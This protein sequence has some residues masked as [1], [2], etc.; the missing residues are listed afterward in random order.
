MPKKCKSK[1]KPKR[2]LLTRIYYDEEKK[3]FSLSLREDWYE[4]PD[5]NLVFIGP[6]VIMNETEKTWH[7]SVHV[8]D[9]MSERAQDLAK[10]TKAE[11]YFGESQYCKIA[12]RWCYLLVIQLY[13]KA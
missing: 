4:K 9:I 7:T 11:F 1:S 2:K 13:A 12:D 10:G 8:E 3:D 5:G 6:P